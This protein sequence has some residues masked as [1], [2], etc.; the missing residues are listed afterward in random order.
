[1]PPW[2]ALA[3]GLITAAAL[4]LTF[5]YEGMERRVLRESPNPGALQIAYLNAWLTAHPDDHG[6]RL[7]LARGLTQ[8]GD[9]DGARIHLRLLEAKA[10]A[11]DIGLAERIALQG[12]DSETAALYALAA[13]DPRRAELLAALR[14]RLRLVAQRPWGASMEDELLER[15]VAIGAGDV[16]TTLYGRALERGHRQ[17]ASWWQ[18]AAEQMLGL[19]EVPL[20]VALFLRAR[21]A[22]PTLEGQR[23]QFIAALQALRADNRLDEALQLA[24][25][26]LG[27][28]AADTATLEYLTRLA[29][30]AGRPDVAQRYALQMLKLSLLH[31]ALRAWRERFATPPPAE[32]VAALE[33]LPP[34]LVRTQAEPAADPRAPALAFDEERYRLSY[35]VFLANGN[36]RDALIVARAAVRAVPRSLPWR[37]RLAQVADWSGEQPLALEQWHAIAVQTGDAAA[38]KQ[39]ELRAPAV[40]DFARWR[41]AVER[42]LRR[43]PD[44]LELIER[45]AEL[46]ERMG[47]PERALAVLQQHAQGPHR[48]T[49]LRK[50]ADLAERMGDAGMRRAALTTLTRE[51]GPDTGIAAA[52]ATYALASGNLPAALALMREA[53]GIARPDE[54]EYW[55]AYAELARASGEPAEALRA[56][57]VLIDSGAVNVNVLLDA[58]QLAEDD[59]PAYAAQLT[60]RA[61]ALDGTPLQAARVLALYDRAGRYDAALAFVEGLRPAQLEVL[62]RDAGF[63]QQRA[64]LWLATDAAGKAVADTRRALAL[65][66]GNNVLRGL[67]LWALVVQRD[68]LTLRAELRALS[69]EAAR[70]SDLWGPV[71][72]AWL[73]LNEP[74]LAL[75]YLTAQARDSRDY[76]W[77]LTLADATELAGDSERAWKLRNAAWR[78]IRAQA[79]PADAPVAERRQRAARLASLAP[80]FEPGDPAERRIAALKGAAPGRA[81]PLARE[82]L[83]AAS[84]S[85][86]RSEL[87]LA[88]LLAQYRSA[89][90][91]PAWAELTLALATHD[92]A[93]IG[94]LLDD[95]PDWLPLYDRVEA[96][97]RAGRIALA[98]SFAFD[99]LAAQPANDEI[100]HRLRNATT[101]RP[102]FVGAVAQRFDQTPLRETSAGLDAAERLAP[103]LQ[104]FGGVR[105]FDR[106]S[107][108]DSRLLSPVPGE[109]R[110]TLG[111]ALRLDNGGQLRATFIH[112]DGMGTRNTLQVDGEA[113]IA[114]RL[115][116]TA[117]AA[118]SAPST[119]STA[120]RIGGE[121]DALWA[122]VLARIGTREYV[123]AAAEASRYRSTDGAGLGSGRVLRLEAGH[124]LRLEYPDLHL[125]AQLSDTDVSARDGTNAQLSSLLPPAARPLAD[126]ATFLPAAGTRVG[127]QVSAGDTAREPYTRGWRPF[128]M[129]GVSYEATRAVGDRPA[130]ASGMGFDWLLG[131]AGSVFGTDRL[132]IGLEGGTRRGPAASPYTQATIRYQWLH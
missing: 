100:H 26:E 22:S 108:D 39:V 33:A 81:E 41:D 44:D 37:Q 51:Y 74:A 89:L 9:F 28:L 106:A 1:M 109:N 82:A 46:H 69:A 112:S 68:A 86:E 21:A 130:P 128:G 110:A 67:L 88:W 66:P 13:D 42:R 119:D 115:W 107:T 97:Q 62:E 19:R 61:Y 34:S 35:D 23:R 105:R 87:A 104:L 7:L 101:P 98:Q 73:A 124:D 20:A 114:R 56:L 25:R 129:L 15:A 123:S 17:S 6:L 24:E 55:S 63:L 49:L 117:G 29:L 18:Q 118:R 85:T 47:E 58:A 14:S 96:A 57:Q 77:V 103:S 116:L 131:A 120:L 3:L 11:V 27:A 80:I 72:A 91:R 127:L 95:V 75:P 30:A 43:A 125:R 40:Y 90:A 84:I 83:L 50:I 31:E 5:R 79:L 64:L 10:A 52:L 38:W 111:A 71:G 113:E 76:L 45:V 126:N 132:A 70:A 53:R 12:L 4:A 122:G 16:A 102:D 60:E 54:I 36:L 121:R 92:G 65:Q 99:G 48:R 8:H 93:W 94:R 59:D 78:V 32:W 2:L